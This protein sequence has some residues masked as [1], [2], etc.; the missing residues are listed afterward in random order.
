MNST[1][2]DFPIFQSDQSL[3]YLDNAST[4]QTPKVVIDAMNTYYVQYRSN[5]HRGMYP[6]SQ[7]ATERYEQA[8]K[9]IAES[10]NAEADEAVFT[11]GATHGL[12]M[13]AQ[14]LCG[15]LKPGDNVVLTRLEHH[16]NLIPWQE[17]KKRYGFEVRY[18]E[19]DDVRTTNDTNPSASSGQA[20]RTTNID[21]ESARGVIDE[22]TKIV[23]FAM[24][25][26]ALGT[27]L[28]VK[29]LVQMTQKVGAVTV[30]DAAQ[31]VAHMPIDVK[32]LDCD[33]LVF[34]GH[35]MYGPTGIG[36]LYGKKERLET[37][38]P[39]HFG[40]EMIRE[41]TYERA[42]WAEVPHKFEA[43]TPNIAGAIGLATAFVYLSHL[44]WE[45]IQ[46]HEEDLKKYLLHHLQ[47]VATI[48]GPQN[49]LDRLGV[50]SFLVDDIHPHDVADILGKQGICVRAGHHCAMPLMSYL[51]IPAG[52]VRVS[53]GVYNTREDVDR[54]VAGIEYVRRVF[55]NGTRIERI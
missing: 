28:P 12:N 46:K 7:E 27:I 4:T 21:L 52:T 42:T 24:V 22:K 47:D 40:G 48:V 17:M 26:N 33:F 37:L 16:A 34:S 2:N 15:N 30:V 8:R 51:G 53:L 5:V 50:V 45:E 19:C 13:L 18:I 29:E 23:S 10:I 11:S 39:F 35:K 31:T 54:L 20:I 32:A 44:R 41:V 38:E 36:V 6:L 43:G 3:V 55:R 14:S 9:T 1:K 25:S 49:S